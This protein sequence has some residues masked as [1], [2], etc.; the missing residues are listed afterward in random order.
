M[1][2]EFQRSIITTDT[3]GNRFS[4]NFS[5]IIRGSSYSDIRKN[6]ELNDLDS[7]IIDLKNNSKFPLQV[8]E[9][10]NIKKEDVKFVYIVVLNKNEK[11]QNSLRFNLQIEGSTSFQ[12]TE[13]C[14]IN[15]KDFDRNLI[16]ESVMNTEKVEAQILIYLGS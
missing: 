16:I 8:F 15:C 1:L 11:D 2:L 4:N 12:T 6:F 9:N 13:F 10:S 3:S 5:N 14:L 7:Q